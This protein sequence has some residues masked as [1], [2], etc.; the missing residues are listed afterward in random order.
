MT[1]KLCAIALMLVSLLLCPVSAQAAD[2]Y[3]VDGVHSS[4]LFR[5]KHFDVSYVYGRINGAGGTLMIDESDPSKSS[6]TASAEVKNIDTNNAQRDTH[7]KGHDFFN[8][9][10]FPTISF[11]S[12]SVKAKDGQWEVSGDMTMHGVTKPISVT[13]TKTGEAP[14]M[15]G[16]RIGFEGTVEIKKSDFGIKGIAGVGD[17]VR[18]IISLEAVKK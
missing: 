11:K 13:L 1:P 4:L 18:L 10:E 14:T 9:K 17:E 5:V 7:L 12:T 16:K 3:Q 2:S 6:F 8:G 15:M